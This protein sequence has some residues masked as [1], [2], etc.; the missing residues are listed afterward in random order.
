MIKNRFIT[1]PMLAG[2]SMM[3][4]VLVT[5]LL[6]HVL[7]NVAYVAICVFTL[8]FTHGR[9]QIISIT[10]FATV[11]LIMGYI[12]AIPISEPAD[13]I[14]FF[15]NRVSAVVVIWFACYF[16]IRYQNALEEE[17]RQRLEVEE[18]RIGEARLRSS[19]EMHQ[20][21]ARNFPEGWI[22]I[23]D[24]SMKYIFAD[25]RGLK[26]AEIKPADL[27]G[28]RFGKILGDDVED[29]LKVAKQGK[30]VAFDVAFN[31]RNYEVNIGPFLS[32]LEINRLLVVVHDI[33]TKKETELRLIKALERERELS[34][35]KSRFV[36]MASHEF[37]TPLT[38]IQSSATLLGKYT[39]DAYEKE[40]ATH[41]TKIKNS[42]KLL[43]EILSDFLS[44]EK[45]EKEDLTSSYETIHLRDLLDQVMVEAESIKRDTQ[46]LEIKYDGRDDIITDRQF[47]KSIIYNLLSNAFKY[48]GEND[49]VIVQVE[50][51]NGSLTISVIDHGVGIPQEEHQYVFDR[52]FRAN[53][54]TNIHGTG[55]GLTIVKK[56]VDHLGGTLSFMSNQGETT[57]FTVKLPVDHVPVHP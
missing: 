49:T 19:Q 26:R 6:T 50:I 55:L 52:F 46:C 24:E 4:L 48:S 20:A 3:M 38:T 54:V 42:V 44:L 22:G 39:G 25:G 12:L 23:L 16:T 56:Y 31:N 11:L 13:Q 36:T 14:T 7:G 30:H 18:R 15:V 5:E 28:K 51:T 37:R 34:E 33:T 43:T 2:I 27:I 32:N 1:W 21:I 47:L 9:K 35:L 45:L 29:F 57:I 41:V 17:E 8:W 10:I 40:K 53:N